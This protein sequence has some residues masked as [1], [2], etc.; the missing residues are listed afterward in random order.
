MLLSQRALTAWVVINLVASAV[1]TYFASW[2]WLE[3]NLRGEDVAR[4]GDVMIWAMGAFP[5]LAVSFIADGLWLFLL[6]R[7]RARQRAPWPT[8]SIFI[9][10]AIWIAALVVN[11]LRF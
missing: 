2:T 3:P 1:F 7:E 11:W 8:P 9:I 6:A 5:V 4:A 10:M